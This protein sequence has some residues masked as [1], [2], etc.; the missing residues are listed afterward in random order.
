MLIDGIEKS[1][2]AKLD[3]GASWKVRNRLEPSKILDGFEVF[4]WHRGGGSVLEVNG[5]ENSK[6]TFTVVRDSIPLAT[7]TDLRDSPLL[8]STIL[9]LP[10]SECAFSATSC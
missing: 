4:V 10:A 8:V 3:T 7:L 1:I 6:V 5:G 2:S 9:A